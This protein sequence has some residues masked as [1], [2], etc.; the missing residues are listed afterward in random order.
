[1]NW[2]ALEALRHDFERID[3]VGRLSDAEVDTGVELQ[4]VRHG[5]R[6]TR[7]QDHLISARIVIV[8]GGRN[9]PVRAG[10]V[11]PFI[12]ER[13]AVAKYSAW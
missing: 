5:I 9:L 7:R 1:M 4:I 8:E 13:E 10:I 3:A 12:G 6:G 11:V 2:P